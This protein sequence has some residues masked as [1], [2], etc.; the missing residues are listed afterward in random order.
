MQIKLNN[1]SD[2]KFLDILRYILKSAG[3]RSQKVLQPLLSGDMVCFKPKNQLKKN[4]QNEIVPRLVAK[5][6]FYYNVHN[7]LSVRVTILLNVKHVLVRLPMRHM[8]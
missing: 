5:S 2:S 6:T 4:Y 1:L 3:S 8:G 7:K